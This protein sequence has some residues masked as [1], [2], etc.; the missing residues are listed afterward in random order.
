[1]KCYT[2]SYL[3][4]STITYDNKKKY[5]EKYKLVTSTDIPFLYKILMLLVFSKL[6]KNFTPYKDF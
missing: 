1:M 4:K 3:L 5:Y 2:L 6:S